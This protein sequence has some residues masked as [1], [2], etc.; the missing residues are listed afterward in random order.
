MLCILYAHW[1]SKEWREVRNAKSLVGHTFVIN[2]NDGPFYSDG[3]DLNGWRALSD[4]IQ[5]KGG[6]VLVYVDTCVAEWDDHKDE[7][8]LDPKI[9]KT[10]NDEA[11]RAKSMFPKAQG[12]FLDDF[13]SKK[14]RPDLVRMVKEQAS[15]WQTIFANPG[16]WAN[17]A[18]KREHPGVKVWIEWEKNNAPPSILK[19]AFIALGMSAPIKAPLAY[20]HS[21]KDGKNPFNTLSPF[22]A[23]ML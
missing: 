21:T 6:R 2:P 15:K 17:A 19:D 13:T 12:M 11:N 10:L 14:S 3:A 7:W 22:F 16:T 20:A 1:S 4:V 9:Y 23:A 8:I 5:G 18:M